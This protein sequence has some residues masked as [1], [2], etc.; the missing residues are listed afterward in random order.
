MS[1]ID[2]FPPGGPIK[3]YL[4][5]I[6]AGV[7]KRERPAFLDKYFSSPPMTAE[8]AFAGLDIKTATYVAENLKIMGYELV[9][10]EPK[11]HVDTSADDK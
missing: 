5:A 4:N 2:D 3:N 7:P 8:L 9:K 6:T 1:S 10:T 11:P